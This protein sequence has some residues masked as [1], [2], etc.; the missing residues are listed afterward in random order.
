MSLTPSQR[1]RQIK[2]KRATVHLLP[3]VTTPE[4]FTVPQVVLALAQA[5]GKIAVAARTLGCTR[6]T[7]YDYKA[8]HPEIGVALEDAEELQLDMTELKL[9]QAIEKGEA[10]AICFYLK[11][12][13]RARGY[14]ERHEVSGHLSLG[15]LLKSLPPRG[16]KATPNT[17]GTESDVQ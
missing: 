7:I 6:Q 15:E 10:W 16:V 9:F 4:R 1:R 3:T 14:V 8:R 12:K 5:R 2:D 11:T 17:G 13:G